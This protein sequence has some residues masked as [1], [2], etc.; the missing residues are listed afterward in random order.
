MADEKDRFGEKIRDL[1][2]AR[3]DQWAAQRDRELLEKLQKKQAEAASEATEAMGTL[4]PR[5]HKPLIEARKAGVAMLICREED[6][7]WLDQT[8][9]NNVLKRLK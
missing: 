4:C 8:E 6:G 9:L 5:C 3:E 2:R 1:E 7:A